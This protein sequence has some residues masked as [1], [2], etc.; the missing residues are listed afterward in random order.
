MFSLRTWHAKKA[1]V[2][3]QTIPEVPQKQH[4][5]HGEGQPL[6]HL[7]GIPI[8]LHDDGPYLVFT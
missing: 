2:L 4:V 6:T 1:D 8:V 3:S 5:A 7:T